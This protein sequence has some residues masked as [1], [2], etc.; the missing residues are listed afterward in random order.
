MST[1]NIKAALLDAKLLNSDA[2]VIAEKESKLAGISFEQ[3]LLDSGF[4][5]STELLNFKAKQ[6]GKDT[7]NLENVQPS[8]SLIRMIPAAIARKYGMFPLIFDAQNNN[9]QVAMES[10]HNVV[11]IDALSAALPS[12][13]YLEIKLASRVD[14]LRAVDRC[15]GAESSIDK[16]LRSMEASSEVEQQGNRD[17]PSL[18]CMQIVDE[19]LSEAV[20]ESASDMH[21]EP[22]VGYLRIRYRIDGV[23]RQMR[24]IHLE[25]WSAILIRIK[26]LS[27]LNIAESRAAQDGRFTKE[28]QGRRLD[29]RVSSFPTV[30]GEAIVIRLLDCHTRLM[31]LAGMNLPATTIERI[32]QLVKKP[33]GLVVV[34]GPTGSGKSTTLYA[35]LNQVRS[36]LVNIVTME[37]PVEYNLPMIRQ[38][39]IESAVKLN[40]ATGV[41]SVLRQD[42][43]II[44]VGETRDVETAEMVLRAA[45][46]GHLVLTTLHCQ[47]A[48]AALARFAD[49]G[50][51]LSFLAGNIQ[52]L[53]SQRLLRKLCTHCK[54]PD[55]IPS[56]WR[57]S[58]G[59]TTMWYR[60][61]GCE[62]CAFTGYSGRQVIVELYE[63]SA[64]VHALLADGAS[65][66]TILKQTVEEKHLT[67]AHVGLQ[68][69]C[70][71]TTSIDEL[72]RV[73][74]LDS[75]RGTR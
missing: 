50:L 1:S 26:V 58:T 53:L 2:L 73:V 22:E 43:D 75:L 42:P 6:A 62:W 64:E 34:C 38:C 41:R 37:D 39:S 23:L 60:S 11:A 32:S 30:R 16:L 65:M 52:A 25:F 7:V 40:F 51:G 72:S 33:A 14:I 5:S 56:D 10:A 24:R 9:L 48:I 36:E 71:G 67:L 70:N 55:D 63:P 68:Y 46:T 19:L 45:L 3:A 74:D 49:L 21:F 12:K 18:A 35:A 31:D 13:P 8:S 27:G 61:I 29:F 15:Y 54:R 28:L 69:V 66:G 44:L 57:T 59:S 47:T 4:I 17:K 20:R